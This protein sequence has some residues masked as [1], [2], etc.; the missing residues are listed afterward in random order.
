MLPDERDDYVWKKEKQDGM[1]CSDCEKNT[2]MRRKDARLLKKKW[3][4]CW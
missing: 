1:T 2:G 3:Q 4:K